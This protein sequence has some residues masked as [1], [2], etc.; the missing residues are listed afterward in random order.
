MCYH[1]LSQ[2]TR[3]GTLSH[4]YG[5]TD[6]S[7]VLL[8]S[9]LTYFSSVKIRYKNEP[10]F[11]VFLYENGVI[12][13]MFKCWFE[14]GGGGVFY[15]SRCEMYFLDRGEGSSIFAECFR[16]EYPRCSSEHH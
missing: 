16:H 10:W 1:G 9:R 6:T 2:N 11:E 15:M 5:C 14:R 4:L 13:K 3:N 12:W 8:K 7:E